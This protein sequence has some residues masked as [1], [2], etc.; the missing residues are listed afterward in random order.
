MIKGDGKTGVPKKSLDSQPKFRS[1]R[2][3]TRMKALKTLNGLID[4]SKFRLEYPYTANPQRLA[5][6]RVLARAIAASGPLLR[7]LDLDEMRARLDKVEEALKR[8]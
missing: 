2:A 5:W 6:A 3:L 7:D 4:I 1:K 8:R